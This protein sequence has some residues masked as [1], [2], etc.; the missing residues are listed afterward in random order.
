M[1]RPARKTARKPAKRKRGGP[2]EFSK[3]ILILVM[4]TYFIAVGVG[5]RLSLIDFTQ[6]STLAMLVG[7]PTATAIGFYAWKARAENIM[8]LKKENP[9]ETEGVAIDPTN[10]QP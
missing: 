10:I 3:L 6:Y 9:K 4:A 1:S 2:F 7:A 8:K 5:V